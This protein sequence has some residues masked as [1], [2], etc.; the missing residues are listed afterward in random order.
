MCTWYRGTTPAGGYQPSRPYIHHKIWPALPG[1]TGNLTI[2][3]LLPFGKCLELMVAFVVIW[4]LIW[5]MMWW[6]LPCSTKGGVTMILFIQS[7]LTE[8]IIIRTYSLTHWGR[9][10]HICVGNQISLGPDNGLSA[11]SHYLNRCWDIVNWTIRNKFQW[12]F[13]RYSY[14]FIHENAFENVVCEMASILSRSQCVK[15]AHT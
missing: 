15:K 1:W 9:V 3:K 4:K 2:R 13:N 5:G 7:F 12:N 10:T 8:N 11:P 6:G 14:I